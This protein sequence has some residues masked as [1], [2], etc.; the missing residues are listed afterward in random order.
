M[1]A[2]KLPIILLSAL[3]AA[4]IV[5]AFCF[6]NNDRKVVKAENT[7]VTVTL[8]SGNYATLKSGMISTV[9][10]EF[11]GELANENFYGKAYVGNK[12]I[13]IKVNKQDTGNDTYRINFN[14]SEVENYS[15]ILNFTVKAADVFENASKTQSFTFAKDYYIG[16]KWDSSA[17][18]VELIT[19]TLG[20]G[21][22]A[23]GDAKTVSINK[24]LWSG[25]L[26]GYHYGNLYSESGEVYSGAHASSSG[27]ATNTG[28]DG[29][30]VFNLS[31]VTGSADIKSFI[32]RKYDVFAKSDNSSALQ[33]ADDYYVSY[34]WEKTPT[35]SAITTVTLGGG[36]DTYV[37]T[38]STQG[39][40]K[41]SGNTWLST[42]GAGYYYGKA[43]NLDGTELNDSD[44]CFY[45]TNATS[46]ASANARFFN[47]DTVINEFV[48]K[49]TVL[50]K[51]GDGTYPF[52][53]DDDYL[54]AC[55]WGGAPTAVGYDEFKM[56]TG[57]SI[58]LGE[59]NGLRFTAEVSKSLVA[60]YEAAGYTVTAGT[61]ILPLDYQAKYGDFAAANFFGNAYKNVKLI[62]L[63]AD[64]VDYN[65]LVYR[66]NGS[67]V[68]ILEANLERDFV[69]RSYLKLTKENSTRYVMACY[70]GMNIDNNARTVMEI[71]EA[72]Y[73]DPDTSAENKTILQ[74]LYLSKKK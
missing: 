26:Q 55:N 20:T 62:N 22:L 35:I 48:I 67:I 43:Y 37:E 34:S 53:F 16:Y 56:R 23:S 15:E 74:N 58:R 42:M 21:K 11:G 18:A 12:T 6:V 51:K 70:D 63:T 57:A 24:A 7:P 46:G 8:G 33:F 13:D 68:D 14:L 61:I 3:S 52:F 27:G 73:N 41:F 39:S 40:I 19:V 50:Y 5:F 59:V 60:S 38:G 9:N 17:K 28:V 32:I 30:F 4:M 25:T 69:G 45:I 47:I 65:D 1:K 44:W 36:T 29:N 66:I 31:S 2:K 10:P 49:S 71:A 64:L 54:V 72:A